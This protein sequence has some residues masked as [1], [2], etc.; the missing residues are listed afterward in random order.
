MGTNYELHL[1]DLIDIDTL[2]KIQDAFSNM[3]GMA[4][5]TTDID[6]TAITQGSNFSD[7]CMNYTRRSELGCARCSQCDKMGAE[8]ALKNGKSTIYF[9]HAGLIDYAA[10]IMANDKMVG[11]FIGGQ[12]LDKAPDPE[13]VRKIAV[14]LGIDPDEYL[15]AVEKVHIL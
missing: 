3:T 1:L 7:F 11:C 2:Q 10:P 14:E 8:L 5:L 15:A 13:Q 12:V 6:G 9:C 4:A